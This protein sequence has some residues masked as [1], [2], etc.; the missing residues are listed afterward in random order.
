MLVQVGLCRTC[1]KTTLLVFPR[2]G[3]FLNVVTRLLFSE[4]LTN[5]DFSQYLQILQRLLPRLPGY[6]NSDD[7][8]SSDSEEDM[9]I[10]DPVSVVIVTRESGTI[11]TNVVTTVTRLQ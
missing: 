7:L 1:S 2:G 6:S 4:S 9:D 8:D 3:S 10:S 11:V 5:K